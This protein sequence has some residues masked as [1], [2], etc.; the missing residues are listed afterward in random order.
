MRPDISN[1]HNRNPKAN[2]F[3]HRAGRQAVKRLE[4]R[5][6]APADIDGPPPARLANGDPRSHH[7]IIMMAVEWQSPAHG[8][9]GNPGF[10]L[11]ADATSFKF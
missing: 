10:G 2:S 3:S 4:T 1:P 6:A 8:G 7:G 5:T 9:R 11:L